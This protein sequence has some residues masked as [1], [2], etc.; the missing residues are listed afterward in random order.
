MYVSRTSTGGMG[1]ALADSATGTDAWARVDCLD[2]NQLTQ[3][4]NVCAQ[5]LLYKEPGKPN[6][7]AWIL[8]G[9]LVIAVVKG[10]R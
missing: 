10:G 5:K 8:G 3:N 7:L 9:L 4:L 2:P 1:F 6:Y